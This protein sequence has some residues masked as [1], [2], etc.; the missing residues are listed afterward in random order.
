MNIF[1]RSKLFI[2][3]VLVP[4]LQ[5]Q[6]ILF[7]GFL[8]S[9]GVSYFYLFI[10]DP[11]YPIEN[12]NVMWLGVVMSLGCVLLGTL[13]SKNKT[14]KKK[15]NLGEGAVAICLVWFIACSISSFVFMYAGFPIPDRVAEFGLFRQYIDGFYES[16][17]GFTTT[18]TS[19]LPSVEVFSRSLLFWRSLTH[20]I[21][22]MGIAYMALTIFSHFFTRRAEIINSEAE[23][24]HIMNFKDEKEAVASGV[25]FLKAYVVMSIICTVLL[26]ISGFY[27][28]Q[29][30][31]D[32]WYTNVFDSL[33]MMFGTLGTGG[34]G[35]YNA[36]V[37]LPIEEA[38]KMVIGGLR[39]P[40]SEW[41]ITVFMLFSAMNFG[42]WFV[43]I[44]KKNIKSMFKNMEFRAFW[45]F[46]LITGFGIA[47]ILYSLG[48]HTTIESSLRYAF[49]NVATIIST[50]GYANDNFALWPVAAQGLLFASY[51]V[52]ACVGST[53]GG[54]KF[55]RFLVMFK[56]IGI[57]IKNMIHGKHETNFSIDG[58]TYN[59]RST[60]LILTNIVLYYLIFLFGAIFI[61]MSSSQ[62]AFVDGTTKDL[63]FVG[64]LTA[65]IANLGNIGPALVDG[66]AGVG[67]TGNYSAFTTLTK[68]L[69]SLLM[70]IGRV[71]VLTAIMILF[72]REE[73]DKVSDNIAHVDFDSD[74]PYVIGK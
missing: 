66:N 26:I 11:N 55:T 57:Q 70:F 16:M 44:F 24:P 72:I 25:D 51:L 53:G 69:M 56:Y 3:S 49:F 22:G 46:V 59:D 43:L 52:G 15:L 20:W 73:N 28:R 74:A 71:G 9:L 35:V 29:V 42:L 39:N 58:V 10:N 32:H 19:I 62:I 34:F 5:S 60:G 50:T 45:A 36:S 8:L 33:T 14:T 54:L 48:V 38:G 7:Y 40:V 12:P 41:I 18:G 4:A 27:F 13:I 37:G 31:Y 61:M 21:G 47:Y 64:A 2:P 65:S 6:I 68:I 1:A 23:S 67:P 17:S 63:D 30:P